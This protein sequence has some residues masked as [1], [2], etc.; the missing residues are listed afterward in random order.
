MYA[1]FFIGNIASGKSTAT[2]YLE[3][4]GAMRVDLDQWAKDLYYPGSDV[5]CEIADAFGL[6]VLSQ[7][8]GINKSVLAE[9][10]FASDEAVRTLNGIV[11]PRLKRRL[12]ELLLP[13]L[14]CSV[15]APDIPL[16][17]VEVSVPEAF[18][19]MFPLADAVVAVSAPLDERRSRAVSRGMSQDDFDARALCQ[20]SEEE[21][22]AMATVVIDNTRADDSLFD[23]LDSWVQSLPIGAALAVDSY[24][25]PGASRALDASV[26]GPKSAADVTEETYE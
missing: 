8:G 24:E 9:R 16:L 20:P 25:G 13:S 3:S 21:L 1:A 11:H 14:C 18:V 22:C 26:Q 5:V 19:D 23:S 17:V 4:R 2:R 15:S 12:S 7:D 6:D 10:A